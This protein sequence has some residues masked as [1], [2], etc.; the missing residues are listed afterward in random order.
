MS[1]TLATPAT[2]AAV[3]ARPRTAPMKPLRDTWLIYQRSLM[4]TLRNPIWV[5]VGLTQPIAFLLLFGP[6][7]KG[8]AVAGGGSGD[9]AYNLFVPGLLVQLALFGTMFVGFGLIAELR[10]GVVERM[11]VTPISR[12]SMLLGRTLRDITVLVVQA[13]LLIVLS[14]PFGLT[15]D[16]ASLVVVLVLV[17]LIGLALAPIS[18]ALGLV[19]KTEDA[20]APLLNFVSLPLLLLSGILL[21]MA[22]APDWLQTVASLNP[23]SHAVDAARALFNGQFSDPVVVTG[24]ALMG[25]LSVLS[26]WVGSRAFGRA[27]S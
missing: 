22:L 25:T 12:G 23:L 5:F 2:T 18:Y 7:L 26:V 4:L 21:P 19:L 13:F 10:A 9:D 24:V 8:L 15:I 14:I 16:P 3:T 27:V 11:R 1:D 17:A 6:L 20:L